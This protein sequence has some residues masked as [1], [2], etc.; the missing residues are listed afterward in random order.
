[1]SPCTTCRHLW[2]SVHALWGNWGAL[3]TYHLGGS[4]PRTTCG[5]SVGLSP[6]TVCRAPGGDPSMYHLEEAPS[7]HHLGVAPSMHHLGGPLLTHHLGGRSPCTTYRTPARLSPHT[8]GHLGG[9]SLHAPPGGHLGGSLHAPPGGAPLYTPPGGHLGGSLHVPLLRGKL[10]STHHVGGGAFSMYHRGRGCLHAPPARHLG[11]SPHIPPMGHLGAVSTHHVGDPLHTQP[12]GL[13]PHTT[14]G[15][16]GGL[17]LC[18]TWEGRL[19]TP[20]GEAL[21]T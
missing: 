2:G 13:S 16:P 3:C 19:H 6:R 5:A 12:R 10:L 1:M 9:G 20:P 18:T 8:V 11:A 14:C 21:S 4:S 7:T 15:A 17:S